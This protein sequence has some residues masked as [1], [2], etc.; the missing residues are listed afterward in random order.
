MSNGNLFRVGL[1]INYTDDS[2]ADYVTQGDSIDPDYLIKGYTLVNGRVGISADDGKWSAYVWGRN[3]TDEYYIT[4]VYNSVDFLLNY[5]GK[6]RT[7][8]L[9]F[10]Y[11]W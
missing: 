4:N 3:L 6:P 2:N 7:Y 11:N 8:G 9:T 1:D 5:A 10:E